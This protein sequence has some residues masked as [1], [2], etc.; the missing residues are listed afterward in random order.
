MKIVNQKKQ[1]IFG[2][3]SEQD[4]RQIIIWILSISLDWVEKQ[5]LE[6]K[7]GDMGIYLKN[8]EQ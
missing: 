2:D 4:K 3:I 8:Q 5:L 1:P 6:V 7:V